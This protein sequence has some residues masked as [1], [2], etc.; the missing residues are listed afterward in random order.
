MCLRFGFF[1][2]NNL[3][4]DKFFA[5]LR[6]NPYLP[7]FEEFEG[8]RPVSRYNIAPAQLTPMIRVN[9][10][11]KTIMKMGKW[12]FVPSGA[13][14]KPKYLPGNARAETLKTSPMFR[15]AFQLHRCLIPASGFYEPKGPKTLKY[16]PWYWFRLMNTNPFMFAGLW[17][18]WYPSEEQTVDT[19]TLITTPPNEIVGEIHD[20][21]PLILHPKDYAKWLSHDDATDLLKPYPAEDME[22]WPVGDGAKKTVK[23]DKTINDD[24]SMIERID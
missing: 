4:L 1:F 15:R 21:M 23:Q 18:R 2:V 3:D 6:D 12:G 7:G 8:T 14:T 20:R 17:G 24:P 22:C 13:T 10:K 9:S 5:E 19:F 16:R 11:S